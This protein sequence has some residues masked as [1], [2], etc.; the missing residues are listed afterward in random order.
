MTRLWE[1]L[2]RARQHRVVRN[3]A[4]MYV[5]QMTSYLFPLLILPFLARVL[6]QEKFG[7]IGFSQMFLYYFMI[8]TDYGFNLT[9]TRE[10][11]VK[12]DEPGRVSE[13]FSAVMVGK[14]LLVVLGWVVLWGV[15]MVTPKLRPDTELYLWSYLGVVGNWLFPLFLYQGLERM[16]QVVKRDMAAKGLALLLI[17]G[18]V[19]G[20]EQYVLAAVAQPVAGLL[21][22]LVVLGRVRHLGVS[23]AWPGWG[24]VRAQLQ[25]AWVPFLGLVAVAGAG[26]SNVVVLGL[27]AT[28][29]EV[30]IFTGAQ[31]I[32]IALRTLVAPVSTALYPYAS[33][34]AGEGEAAAMAFVKRYVGMLAAPFLLGGVVLLVGSPV[35]LPWFLGEKY[36]ESA[37]VLQ[38]MAMIPALFSIVQVYS[39][40]YMLACGY[41]REWRRITLTVTVFNL[42]LMVGLLSA[43][44]GAYAIAWTALGS[45]AL[46][47]M[48]Y[49]RFYRGRARV[50]LAGGGMN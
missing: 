33:Q 45:E 35:L 39:T 13:I 41:D 25:Q 6:S 22:G 17:F 27:V 10:V 47:A 34:K 50:V 28:P 43:V 49:W 9:A 3:A 8:L 44:R 20:D 23:W 48:L 46:A 37:G 32:I 30:A 2:G 15:V 19:R 1:A 5:V 16:D 14:G 40:Y 11:A 21:C 42:V 38:I 18:L 24:M 36:R 26:V 4:L 31:R 29:V 7:L 12:R